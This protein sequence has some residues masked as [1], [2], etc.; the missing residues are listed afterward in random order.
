MDERPWDPP[1]YEPKSGMTIP[2]YARGSSDN[3]TERI[4][5]RSI[6][7]VF[8][9][10]APLSAFFRS[11]DTTP[12]GRSILCFSTG[13][14]FSALPKKESFFFYLSHTV[15]SPVLPRFRTCRTAAQTTVEIREEQINISDAPPRMR[16]HPAASPL[17]QYLSPGQSHDPAY[18]T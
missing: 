4:P 15:I 8:Q 14:N 5:N 10:S 3:I 9:K 1:Q 7:T 12:T 17:P 16:L 11:K 2:R 13:F 6:P 18:H